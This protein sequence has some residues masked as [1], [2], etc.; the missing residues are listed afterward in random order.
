[1]SGADSPARHLGRHDVAIVGSGCIGSILARVLAAGGRRVLLLERGRHPRFAL[2]ESSTPLA[3]LALERLSARTGLADLRQLASHGAWTAHLSQLGRGL[4]RGFTFYGHERGRPFANGPDNGRRLLVAAS[5]DDLVADTHWLRADVD[6]HLV[7]RAAA[8]GVAYH[9]GVELD[10]FEETAAGVRLAGRDGGGRIVAEAA[11]LIDASGPGGFLAHALDVPARRGPG[12]VRSGLLY[13][14]LAEAGS[15]VA[16]ARAAGADMPSGPYPDER[17]AVHHLLE[18]GWMYV[19]PFDHG[20]ASCGFLVEEGHA[21]GLDTGDPAAAW[22]ELLARYPTLEAQ[23]GGARPVVGPRWI[24]RVQHRLAVA[25]GA[26][27][28]LLPHAYAFVDPMFSTGIAWGL[29]AVE[30]LA[31]LLLGG[32]GDLR[33]DLARYGELLAAE[34][35]QIDRIVAL[36]YAARRDF[37]AFT[38]SSLLYFANVSFQEVRQRLLPPPAEGWAWEGFLGAGDRAREDELEEAPVRLEGGSE[39]F[40]RWVAERIA[41]RDVIGLDDPG[42]R[43]LHPVDLEVLVARAPRLGLTGAELR[44]LLPRLRGEPV[45]PEPARP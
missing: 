4:K 22:R 32:G 25:S 29:L 31:D 17:A 19:L 23:L 37:A 36:A 27:W 30:R 8:E 12:R 28:A 7:G 14:H 40:A 44:R 2:G 10:A 6:L 26:R 24:G 21:G 33:R 1:M 11:F 18:E 15:F 39:P 9:D 20:V 38:A 34:A 43:N 5:P 13:A 3:A 16:A 42:R 35:D 41:P 45:A